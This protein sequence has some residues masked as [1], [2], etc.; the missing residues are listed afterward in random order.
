MA[1]RLL[2]TVIALLLVAI[3]LP[4]AGLADGDPASDTLLAENV[5][6]PYSATV[7]PS[8]QRRLDAETT[9][10]ARARFPIKVAIIAS[11][12]DLGVITQLFLQ[13]QTY[14]EFLEQ[15]ISYQQK[16]L[17][18]VVM[19]SGYG[20]QGLGPAATL[21]AASLA[22]PA[23]GQTDDLTRAAIAAVTKLAAAA[24]HPIGPSVASAS[25][26]GG[27]TTLTLVILAL[28]AVGTAALVI[29]VRRTRAQP[30]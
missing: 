24:G 12:T 30:G 8:L 19:P 9:A 22:K 16:Q 21:A 1:A 3:L 13:P 2:Q 29:V 11:P 20:V 27:S 18:L 17:L 25:S 10:A 26:G 6:Y 5:F 15:E 7:S 4:A 28:A 14:A 23:G